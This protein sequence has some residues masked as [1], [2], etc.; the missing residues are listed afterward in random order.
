M[1]FKLKKYRGVI[2]H[3]TEHSDAEFEKTL[4]LWFQKWHEELVE[5]SLQH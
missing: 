1:R 3:D 4:T 5:L 2:F